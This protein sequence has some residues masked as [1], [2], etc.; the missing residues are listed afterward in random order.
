MFSVTVVDA[1]YLLYVLAI[2][3][4][5]VNALFRGDFMAYPEQAVRFALCLLSEHFE[6]AYGSD[7]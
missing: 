7:L 4:P 1:I 2:S 5:C 3:A 6:F